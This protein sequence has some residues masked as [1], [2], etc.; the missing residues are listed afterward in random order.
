VTEHVGLLLRRWLFTLG[1]TQ[2]ELARRTGLTPKHVNGVCQGY[3]NLSP[4]AAVLV[5]S[6]TG[7]PA[8]VWLTAQ[9]A[10]DLARIR[11]QQ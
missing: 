8:E 1:M 7:V 10:Y 11:S 9:V 5:E 2:A 4:E 6:A 3:N